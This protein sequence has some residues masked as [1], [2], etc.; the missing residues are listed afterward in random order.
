MGPYSLNNVLIFVLGFLAFDEE[1]EEENVVNGLRGLNVL[2]R[3]WDFEEKD[4]TKLEETR[5]SLD[6]LLMFAV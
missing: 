2:R 1:E 6:E 3:G 4:V 5:A